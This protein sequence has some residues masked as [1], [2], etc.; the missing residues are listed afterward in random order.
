[1]IISDPNRIKQLLLILTYNALKYIQDG[2][3]HIKAKKVDKNG[4]NYLR[5]Y[6]IDS[7]C[8]FNDD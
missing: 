6:V 5:F 7:G 3:I 8:G 1:M 2:Y 4:D